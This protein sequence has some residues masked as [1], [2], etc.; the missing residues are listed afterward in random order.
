[1]PST[2][3]LGG[4]KTWDILTIP[5]KATPRSRFF[6]LIPVTAFLAIASYWAYFGYRFKCLLGV[7]ATETTKEN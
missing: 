6:A 1:M 7:L 4:E 2:D 5:V 3:S